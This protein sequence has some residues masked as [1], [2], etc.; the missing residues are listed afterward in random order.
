MN[1]WKAIKRLDIINLS[2]FPYTFKL[3]QQ[4]RAKLKGGEYAEGYHVIKE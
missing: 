2:L 1:S 3:Y 4:S